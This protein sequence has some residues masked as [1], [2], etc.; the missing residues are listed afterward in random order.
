[1]KLLLV[2]V[3][4]RSAALEVREKIDLIHLPEE[5]EQ[6]VILR[7]DPALDPM[8]R[9]GIFGEIGTPQNPAGDDCLSL[10]VW[11]PDPG[12]TGLPVLVWIH[13]GAFYAGSGIDDVYNG[14]AFAR[15]GIVCVTINYRLGVQVPS[16]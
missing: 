8:V 11:T 10:N 12:S 9:L 1:M 15:D 3:N 5:C 7:Y 6:P 14:S 16:R 2:G 13:G 4:H